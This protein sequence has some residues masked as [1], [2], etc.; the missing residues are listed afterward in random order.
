MK[1]MYKI[2]A[3]LS[4]LLICANSVSVMADTSFDKCSMHLPFGIPQLLL[5]PP[6]TTTPVC[7]G[8]YAVLHDDKF[9]VP[10]WVAYRLTASHTL[11]CVKRAN[12]FHADENLPK[13]HR[14]T[15][16]DYAKSGLDQGHQGPAQ[17]FAWDADRMFDSFSMANMSPQV[18]GLNRKQWERLEASVRAWATDRKELL[19]YVGPVLL[20]AKK[21]IG[22][23]GVIVPLAFWKVVVDPKTGDAL[24]FMMPQKDI[25]KGKLVPWQS[26]IAIVEQAAGVKLALPDGIDRNV[27][28]KLWPVNLAAWNKK[29][30]MACGG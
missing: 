12:Q 11:G 17:D 3:G 9:L 8:G 27:E 30:K 2:F 1:R 23:N 13:E 6:T 26:S 20:N 28:P 15:P 19:V 16:T 4:A 29:H 25:P 14:A 21:K 5:K 18:P 10:R 7:H 24:A 22:R